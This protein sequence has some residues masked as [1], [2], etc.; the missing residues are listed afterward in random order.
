MN[1]SHWAYEQ[2]LTMSQPPH[3]DDQDKDSVC[4]VPEGGGSPSIPGT[5]AAYSVQEMK[6]DLSCARDV[7]SCDVQAIEDR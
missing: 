2:C 1:W 4:L 5:I 6:I 3:I 7:N